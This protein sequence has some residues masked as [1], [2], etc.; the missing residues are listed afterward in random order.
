MAKAVALPS[1]PS[2]QT[3]YRHAVI[4]RVHLLPLL[5]LLGC[6]QDGGP[7]AAEPPP[8]PARQLAGVYPADF[9]CESL[10]TT[11]DLTKV[12]GGPV[13]V[14]DSPMSMPRGLP[15]PCNY[16]VP[17]SAPTRPDAGPPGPEA[18]TFDIDCRDGMKQRADKLFEQYTQQSADLVTAYA[19]AADAGALKGDDAGIERHAPEGAAEV[20][21]GARGLDHHGQ[22]L[23]FID[24]DA[25]C[26]VRVIGPDSA[27]R[28]ELAKLLASR[29]TFANA[30]MTP[31]PAP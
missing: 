19:A 21:V 22:G 28:L 30:P 2:P 16:L 11:D 7:R 4:R 9:H 18:W 27:R 29:L 5:A 31:R 25:P 15:R 6:K 13:Q 26:Y 23:L 8:G 10:V 17:S 12:L 3:V 1:S 20:N 14:I 24:D